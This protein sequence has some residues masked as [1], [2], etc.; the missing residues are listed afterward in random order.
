MTLEGGIYHNHASWNSLITTVLQ[1][2]LLQARSATYNLSTDQQ[3]S[4][5]LLF[6]LHYAAKD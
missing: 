5:L 6:T 1:S 4:M 3:T 2:V